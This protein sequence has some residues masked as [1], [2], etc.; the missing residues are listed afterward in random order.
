MFRLT[1]T[2]NAEPSLESAALST[3][4]GL[5]GSTV[6]IDCSVDLLVMSSNVGF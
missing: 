6:P 1:P 3:L 2:A 5:M 4:Y